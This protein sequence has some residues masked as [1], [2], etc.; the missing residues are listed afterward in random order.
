MHYSRATVFVIFARKRS[1][2]A[3]ECVHWIKIHSS[4]TYVIHF[5]DERMNV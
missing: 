2:K 1:F 4:T 5:V 3:Y